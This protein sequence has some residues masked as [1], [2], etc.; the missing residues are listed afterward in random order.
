[1]CSCRC[2]AVGLLHIQVYDQ[3]GEA[4]QAAF[5]LNKRLNFSRG[6]AYDVRVHLS[7]S[8]RCWPGISV[9]RVDLLMLL[10]QQ[11]GFRDE[12]CE[13]QNGKRRRDGSG[14]TT[15][16]LLDRQDAVNPILSAAATGRAKDGRDRPV[17]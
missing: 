16:H 5:A 3:A 13:S 17:S 10:V 15:V 14:E 6:S 11:V 1:M 12:G 7:T 4:K 9:A 2:S 8:S